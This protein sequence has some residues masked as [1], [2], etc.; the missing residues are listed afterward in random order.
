MSKFISF[1]AEESL[2]FI[3]SISTGPLP[4]TLRFFVYGIT[5]IKIPETIIQLP[6]IKNDSCQ[7]PVIS[8]SHPANG[9]PTR[10]PIPW[11]S[12]VRP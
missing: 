10:F 8:N 9:G 5:P 6:A 2:L 3:R 11:H 1:Y 4:K 7:E 12:K